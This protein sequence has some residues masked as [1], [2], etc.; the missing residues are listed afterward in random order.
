M[1]E[2]FSEGRRREKT[3]FL[4]PTN[5]SEI[6]NIILMLSGL[7][8]RCKKQTLIR[9]ERLIHIHFVPSFLRKTSALRRRFSLAFRRL[10]PS[11][12]P[13]Y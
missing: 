5:F 1:Q 13:M 11:F 2:Y 8:Y 7:K 4:S 10:F 3:V 6:F 9:A 12:F